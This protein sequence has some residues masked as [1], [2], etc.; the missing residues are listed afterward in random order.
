MIVAQAARLFRE[1]GIEGA[2]VDEVMA[3]AG[4][5]RGG[6]YAHFEDKT[7]LVAEAIRYA[8]DGA[9]ENLF[10]PDMPTEPAAWRERA[11]RR[12]LSERHLDNPGDGCA[13]TSLG[14]DAARSDQP[15]RDAMR[16]Q[17][18]RVFREL[19][20]RMGG[21]PTT[22]RQR[23]ISLL[24]TCVGAMTLA[25]AVGDRSTAREILGACREELQSDHEPG[26]EPLRKNN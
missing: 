25:R 18:E 4:L 3:A 8:F 21:D 7:Q 24:S 17:V 14:T 23:A 1:R 5:T 9:V 26:R 19:E 11:V 6:F 15:V 12:Y 16:Q 13:A 22:A 10:G 2:S 20:R